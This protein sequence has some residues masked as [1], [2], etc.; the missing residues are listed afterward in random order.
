GEVKVFGHN[1][2]RTSWSLAQMNLR[3]HGVEPSIEYDYWWVSH[4]TEK[5]DIVFANPPF[6]MRLPE[7]VVERGD[8]R[9]GV[10]PARNGNYAWLQLVVARL[11]RGGRA[12]VVMP[13][14]AGFPTTRPQ[15]AIPPAMAA[16]APVEHVTRL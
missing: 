7:E 10:P 2:N 14:N 16:D 15:N 5:F 3:L 6:N 11:G 1:P 13:S 12:A 9:Y 8:W 4:S